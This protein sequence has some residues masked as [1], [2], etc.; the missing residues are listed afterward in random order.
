MTINF[1][2]SDQKQKYYLGI[3]G[4][5]V[6]MGMIWFWYEYI[7][8]ETLSILEVQEQSAK[9]IKIDVTIFDSPAFQELGETAAEI[10]IPN[11]VRRENPF[12]ANVE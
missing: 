1:I 11:S 8:E 12:K 6:F 5:V 7:R 3:L 10:P 4:A 2:S 9:E